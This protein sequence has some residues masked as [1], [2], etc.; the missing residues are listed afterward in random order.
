MQFAVIAAM[1]AFAV[2]LYGWGWAFRKLFRMER[3]TWAVT[4]ALGLAA[5]VFLG[6]VLNAARIAYPVS[7]AALVLL[8]LILAFNAWHARFGGLRAFRDAISRPGWSSLAVW[9]AIFLI[10]A[11]A[12]ATALPPAAYNTVDDY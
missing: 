3:G 12:V 11:F 7:L 10:L 8:G 5:A 9:S 6:G 2:A 1:A 4:L